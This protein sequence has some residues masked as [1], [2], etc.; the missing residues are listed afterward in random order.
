MKPLH[1]HVQRLATRMLQAEVASTHEEASK[2]LEKAE[3][4][5]KKFFY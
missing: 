2:I 1:H 4:H 5:Q 3:K